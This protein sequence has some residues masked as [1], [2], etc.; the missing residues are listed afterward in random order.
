DALGEEP[1]ARPV[2]RL[3]LPVVPAAA[4]AHGARE[5]PARGAL[6]GARPSG[7]AAAGARAA[8]GARR[9]RPEGPLP[10]STV[11]RR[12]G[13]RRLLPRVVHHRE[14]ARRPGLGDRQERSH[15][16]LAHHRL[17][18]ARRRGLR[19]L[20]QGHA[21]PVADPPQGRGGEPN[22]DHGGA[23]RLQARTHPLDRHGRAARDPGPDGRARGARGD[24]EVALMLALNG[25]SYVAKPPLLYVLLGGAFALAGPSETTARA[26]PALCALAAIAA[27]AWL[28]AKLLGARGGFVA[29]T[30]LLTSA[31][32]FAF[33][34]YVRP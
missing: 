2:G 9:A 16:R 14:G 24:R 20:R 11:G 5:R 33:A 13:A 17:A 8:R 31:G 7:G 32:F 22:D 15:R 25:V 29:G 23:Q 27:T 30:A 4:V 34:R 1:R 19:R 26:V 3:R 28:G 21:A 12:A 6:R 18:Q 10:A